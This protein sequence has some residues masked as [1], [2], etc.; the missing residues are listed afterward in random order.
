MSF[1]QDHLVAGIGLLLGPLVAIIGL[2]LHSYALIEMGLPVEILGL[3]IFF[4]SVI[5]VLYQQ[6]KITRS[7]STKASA[8]LPTTQK[9]PIS[10]GTTSSA[11]AITGNKGGR[12]Y[13]SITPNDLRKTY[14]G[15]T[16]AEA[17]RLVK[18]HLN[19]WMRL[20]GTV[21]DLR[22]YDSGNG[23]VF[24]K[25][26]SGSVILR[27]RREWKDQI[28]T[29]QAGFSVEAEG[30]LSEVDSRNVTLENCELMKPVV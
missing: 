6:H 24:L 5:G 9:Q 23:T 16:M 26:D 1:F 10:V 21:D 25:D 7:Q 29:L 2:V 19:K 27:F 30:Q 4:L 3:V 20:T 14:S 12:I 15:R 13:T 22:I 17:D 11:P 28:E 18:T 8:A